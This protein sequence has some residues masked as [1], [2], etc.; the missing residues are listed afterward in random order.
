MT[1]EKM[2]ESVQGSGWKWTGPSREGQG[3][4]GSQCGEPRREGSLLYMVRVGKFQLHILELACGQSNSLSEVLTKSGGTSSR[5]R[6]ATFCV[7]GQGSFS[8]GRIMEGG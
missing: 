8:H 4:K 5:D 1:K 7:Y 3:L 6:M 2:K